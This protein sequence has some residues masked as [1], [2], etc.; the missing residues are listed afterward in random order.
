MNES[1]VR[2]FYTLDMSPRIEE[3]GDL[4]GRAREGEERDGSQCDM[5]VAV[6]DVLL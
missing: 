1:G 3:L 4:W 5:D 2:I 6:P